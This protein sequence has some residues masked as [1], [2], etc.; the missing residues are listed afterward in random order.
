MKQRRPNSKNQRDISPPNANANANAVAKKGGESVNE[1]TPFFAVPR[2]VLPLLLGVYLLLTALLIWRVP[3][4]AAPD[5][6]AHFEYVNFLAQNGHLPVFVPRGATFSGYEYHQPPLYYALCA[7]LWK[8][9]PQGAREY[10]SRTV[11]LLCGLATLWVLWR[12][13]R[14]LLPNRRDL[15]ALSTFFAALLPLHQAVG[16]SAGND[17]LADLICAALFLLVARVCKNAETETPNATAP[18][19][20][21]SNAVSS[22]IATGEKAFLRDSLLIGALAGLGL[23]TKNTTLFVSLAAIGALFFVPRIPPTHEAKSSTRN[24]EMANS[25]G[26]SVSK[27]RGARAVLLA[28]GAMFLVGGWWLLRNKILYGDPLAARVFDEAFS[29]SSPRPSDFFSAQMAQAFGQQMTPLIYGRALFLV[30]FCTFWGVFGGPGNAIRVLN[31]FGV[32]GATPESLPFLPAMLVLLLLT[33]FAI[34]GLTRAASHWKNCA[35][36]TRSAL[37][38]WICGGVFMLI[39]F[40]NFNLIQFQAQARYLHPVL[41]PIAFGFACGWRHLFVSRAA[42]M[43]VCGVFA[44]TTIGLTLVN[45]C[46]WRTL[47]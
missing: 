47:V 4:G 31:P 9:L 39:A 20:I 10:S 26:V 15:A 6:N 25:D 16:A 5:E 1:A 3:I 34:W 37:G 42:L 22:K 35:P 17:S 32:R 2:F 8:I 44:L 40:A 43:L 7:P 46:F 41:L 18:N 33:L 27:N 29:K 30:L 28:I 14:I 23:L 45:I 12:A 38:A 21:V 24:G 36:A 13:L 11:S 19:A